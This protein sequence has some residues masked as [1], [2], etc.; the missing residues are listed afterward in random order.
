V[1]AGAPL[2]TS[3]H[4]HYTFTVTATGRNGESTAVSVA[5]SVAGPP[6]VVISSPKDGGV[7]TRG[8]SVG[9]N[10]GCSDDQFGPG[11]A[12]C[13]APLEI[14]TSH[15]GTFTFTATAR[16]VD[17][18]TGSGTVRYRVAYPSNRFRIYRLRARRDGRISL[19]VSLPGPGTLSIAESA[20]APS[21][22]L[23]RLQMKARRA[24]TIAVMLQPGARGRAFLARRRTAVGVRLAI[25][26]TPAGGVARTMRLSVRVP[27]QARR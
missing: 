23:S 8:Q 18:Q 2:D 13:S 25:T 17:G 20:G 4:G 15:V 14:D 19:R 26:Y 27:A 10:F 7:Y 1:P 5:Y 11:L 3:A 6:T 16:S 9:V 24:G 21:F 22:R 12:D